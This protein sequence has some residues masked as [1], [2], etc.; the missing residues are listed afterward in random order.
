[1]RA[2]LV[3]GL[4]AAV[5]LSTAALVAP[6]A[7]AA[8]AAAKTAVAKSVV[9]TATNVDGFCSSPSGFVTNAPDLVDTLR[10][11]V[12]PASP[13][14]GSRMTVRVQVQQVQL[15]PPYST[16]PRGI[17]R[18]QVVV[19]VGAKAHL[20]NGPVNTSAVTGPIFPNG[21]TA[22]A[23]FKA[24]AKGKRT[25]SIQRIVYNARGAFNGT[26]DSNYEGFDLVCSGGQN[27]LTYATA[28]SKPR[29]TIKVRKRL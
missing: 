14:A 8:P 5:A 26:W 27:P 16:Y 11:T 29:V 19:K 21:W 22:R 6:S 23:T 3:G 15:T 20:L 7:V 17:L 13:R 24:P 25:V 2:L 12:S 4:S 28:Y 10:L 18:G 9:R 1:M